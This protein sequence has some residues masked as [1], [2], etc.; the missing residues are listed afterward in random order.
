MAEKSKMLVEDIKKQMLAMK[1]RDFS[2]EFEA[3]MADASGF[4][5]RVEAIDA[6]DSRPTRRE[7]VERGAPHRAEPDDEHVM[8]RASLDAG[9]SL[10]TSATHL[11]L[12]RGNRVRRLL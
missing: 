5:S 10:C 6:N 4:Q 3:I 12:C 8:H 7:M 1:D 2:K 11:G 9:H